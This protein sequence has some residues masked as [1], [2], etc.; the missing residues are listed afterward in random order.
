MK[1]CLVIDSFDVGGRESVVVELANYF[2]RIGHSVYVVILDSEKCTNISNLDANI[3]V[4][5]FNIIINNNIR[6]DFSDYKRL[7][8]LF[9]NIDFDIIHYHIYA[10]RLILIALLSKLSKT[11]AV[12]IR[13]VHTS[14]LFYDN[15]EKAIDKI[16]L[17]SERLAIRLCKMKVIGISKLIDQRNRVIFKNDTNYFE[18]IYNGIDVTKYGT[19]NKKNK[20]QI[21][22]VYVSRFADGKNHDFILNVWSEFSIDKSVKLYLAGD[23][24]LEESLKQKYNKFSDKICFLGSV[25][26]IP[27]LLKNMD[28]ALFPSSYE[29]FSLVLLEYFASSLPV[30]ASNIPAFQEIGINNKN[31]V[32]IP[33]FD[34]K[35]YLSSM[36]KLY[37]SNVKRTFLGESAKL[38]VSNYD[39]SI[40]N[41]KHYN[42]YLKCVH[43]E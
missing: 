37:N 33:S 2:N 11:K 40:F 23:G 28:V 36:V 5:K 35:L 34:S 8:S 25:D 31:I 14:G 6:I 17:Y 32:F 20:N 29:G 18:L 9:K 7:L 22:F 42:L 1:I 38:T 41:K 43:R 13:T 10:F 21:D 27:E 4:S 12:Q 16:R 3:T 24:P 15:T 30:I 39:I 19:Y 26:D